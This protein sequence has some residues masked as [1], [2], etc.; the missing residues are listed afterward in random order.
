MVV[1]L[2]KHPSA[3]FVA[4]YGEGPA[5]FW[6]LLVRDVDLDPSEIVHTEYVFVA[7]SDQYSTS[8]A[9]MTKGS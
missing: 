2:D 5:M 6:G 4:H 9:M 1:N 3:S 8:I 7:D